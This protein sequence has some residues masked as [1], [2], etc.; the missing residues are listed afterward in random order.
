VIRGTHRLAEGVVERDIVEPGEFIL[1]YRN[2]QGY[3]PPAIRVSAETDL[4]D[5][6]PDVIADSPPR[7]PSFRTAHGAR[8]FGRNGTYLVVRQIEQHVDRFEQ[9]T[10]CA[11]ER[12][13][14]NSSR[15][16]NVV[17]AKIDK[18]WI[19]A[20][21]M[22]R[23]KNGVPLALRPGNDGGQRASKSDMT[24]NDFAYAHD[25]P[26]GQRCPFGAHIRRANP[27]DGLRPGDDLQQAITNRHRLLR[28][29]R[30]YEIEAHGDVPAEKGIVFTCLCADLERQFE[31]VQQ[32]WIGS[33]SFHGL[34]GEVDPMIGSPEKDAVFTIPTPSGPITLDG[35]QSFVTV[36][37]GGYFFMPSYSA[38]LY[39]WDRNRDEAGLPPG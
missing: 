5:R 21:M 35:L 13:N 37:A 10:G 36:R 9:F 27:R 32:T 4:N 12:L 38:L 19:A 8:D 23:W 34:T 17:G 26:Q 2:N 15:L 28:R 25:D 1:G 29:G 3:Y 20:K 39:L 16:A 14:R 18:E 24:A 11:A 30:T 7:F 31:F 33:S 22:G 6:L